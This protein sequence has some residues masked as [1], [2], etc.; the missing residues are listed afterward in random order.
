MLLVLCVICATTP[1]CSTLETV[2]F[3][4]R[5]TNYRE[6][7]KKINQAYK[8]NKITEAEYIDLKMK[9]DMILRQR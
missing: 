7:D 9:N 5:Q 1:S 8:S 2:V 3:G 6:Y 4:T